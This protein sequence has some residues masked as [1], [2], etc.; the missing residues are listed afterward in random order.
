MGLRPFV[1]F[2]GFG[3]VPAPRPTLQSLGAAVGS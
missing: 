3:I 1:I 2:A